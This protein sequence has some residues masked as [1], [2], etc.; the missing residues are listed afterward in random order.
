MRWL[1]WKTYK[2]RCPDGS[3]KTVYR[4]IDDAFPLYIPGWKA[5]VAA[6]AK[7]GGK[8]SGELKGEYAAAMQGM[9]VALDEFNRGLM[10]KF[11]S[12][13][14]V[15]KSD[16]CCDNGFLQREVEK[17]LDDHRRLQAAKMQLDAAIEFARLQPQQSERIAQMLVEIGDRMSLPTV[18]QGV[19]RKIEDSRRIAREMAEGKDEG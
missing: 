10:M 9:L 1:F 19:P 6:T 12:A 4:N 11:R 5:G 16:P 8:G 18:S 2:V 15:Y 17:A 14:V 7:V 3:L 13:Y